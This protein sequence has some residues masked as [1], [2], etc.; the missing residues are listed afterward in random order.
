MSLCETLTWQFIAKRRGGV[1]ND[2]DDVAQFFIAQIFS[3]PTDSDLMVSAR[4]AS[5][6]LRFDK[7]LVVRVLY[8]LR[9]GV[10]L[11]RAR[12]M[13]EADL[14]TDPAG[15][16]RWIPEHILEAAHPDTRLNLVVS[17]RIDVRPVMGALLDQ[18]PAEPILPIR[19]PWV[20]PPVVRN[21]DPK[22]RHRIQRM[23]HLPVEL[24]RF[25][26]HGEQCIYR[27][28]QSRRRWIGVAFLRDLDRYGTPKRQIDDGVERW[29]AEITV[30]GD[31]FEEL[32]KDRRAASTA[33]Q[34]EDM[35]GQALLSYGVN[36]E[37]CPPRA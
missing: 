23:A 35:T 31:M 9:P 32:S 25:G 33:T 12:I 37:R 3:P 10:D 18:R 28:R 8:P 13:A 21:A 24:P 20:M 6:C 14:R 7:L 2:W 5:R 19:R 27:K 17:D 15:K 30:A 11:Q 22:R 29:L 4:I 16:A 36:V 1:T 34:N 26:Q